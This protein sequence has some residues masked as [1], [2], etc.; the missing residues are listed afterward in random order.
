MLSVEC[1]KVTQ[2]VHTDSL[3]EKNKEEEVKVR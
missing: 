1:N 3:C 2:V